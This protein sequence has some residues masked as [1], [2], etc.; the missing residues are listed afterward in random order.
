MY[1]PTS[2]L[3]SY[4]RNLLKNPVETDSL[5]KINITYRYRYLEHLKKVL[6][7][8]RYL[9]N[10]HRRKRVLEKDYQ[11]FEPKGC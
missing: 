6:I 11:A 1:Q 5:I 4:I 2:A 8:I 10:Q 7:C 3:C 9:E